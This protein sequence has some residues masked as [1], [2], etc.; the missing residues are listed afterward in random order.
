MSLISTMSKMKLCSETS[1]CSFAQSCKSWKANR[2]LVKNLIWPTGHPTLKL[3]YSQSMSESS[4]CMPRPSASILQKAHRPFLG[5]SLQFW[6]LAHGLAS[7]PPL[8]PCTHAYERRHITGSLDCLTNARS[9]YPFYCG[10][11][12]L[13]PLF[14]CG[15]WGNCWILSRPMYGIPCAIFILS[16]AFPLL[17]RRTILSWSSIHPFQTFWQKGTHLKSS[18]TNIH[19]HW[20]LL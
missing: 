9:Y 6:F 12:R 18:P 3:S 11:F 1:K 8:V 15:I 14:Q 5:I 17:S 13:L 2:I 20:P 4:L 7:T 16:Y 19:P 10:S